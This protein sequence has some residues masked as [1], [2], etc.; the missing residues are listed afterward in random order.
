MVE[1]LSVRIRPCDC[2]LLAYLDLWPEYL[3]D[4]PPPGTSVYGCA[5]FSL[6]IHTRLQIEF[7]YNA[8]QLLFT[9]TSL[10]NFYLAFFF[11]CSACLD[12]LGPRSRGSCIARFLCHD[13]GLDRC[14]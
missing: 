12:C 5:H 1:R 10:A 9:W 14:L 4:V 8:V 2:L 3:P 13:Y 6:L 7:I 11:V